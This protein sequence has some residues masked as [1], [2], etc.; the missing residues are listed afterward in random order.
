MKLALRG[1]VAAGLLVDAYIHFDLASQYDPI[2]SGTVSQGDLFRVEAVAALLA[3]VIVVAFRRRATDLLALSVAAGGV[4]AVLLYRYVDVGP[5]GPLP[6]MYEPIWF[7][8]KSLS[9]VAEAVAAVAAAVVAF[10]SGRSARSDREP[11]YG[12]AR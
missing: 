4:V 6:S 1:L 7:A 8:E 12:T 5:I 10:S 2:T 9:L 3:A 11:A